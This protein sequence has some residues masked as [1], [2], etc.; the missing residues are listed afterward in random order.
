MG[1]LFLWLL[2]LVYFASSF[3]YSFLLGGAF[4][5]YS[6]LL[7]RTLFAPSELAIST[8]TAVFG[9]PV[10]IMLMLQRQRRRELDS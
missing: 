1:N 5:M 10:V 3:Q 9:A 8:V 6:D 4:C 2:F 7:A